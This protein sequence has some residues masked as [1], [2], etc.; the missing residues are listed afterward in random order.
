[1]AFRQ[2]H[3]NRPGRPETELP[4][5]QREPS[6]ARDRARKF[7]THVQMNHSLVEKGSLV[8][9]TKVICPGSVG[10]LG[11]MTGIGPGS[12][13]LGAGPGSFWGIGPGLWH[14][15]GPMP[16]QHGTWLSAEHLSRFMA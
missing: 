16:P 11:P 2:Q 12:C 4:M 6:D 14:E 9:D 15:P 10:K 7:A 3:R 8:Q 1:M 13:R 5:R